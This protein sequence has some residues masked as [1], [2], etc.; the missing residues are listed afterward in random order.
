M[1]PTL[2]AIVALLVAGGVFV[3]A[4]FALVGTRRL[5]VEARREAGDRRARSVAAAL[6]DLPATLA[7]SQV[8][9]AACAVLL[10]LLGA[11]VVGGAWLR[12]VLAPLGWAP[13]L[14]TA[15]AVGAALLLVGVLQVLVGELVPRSLAISRPLE[16]ALV[17]VP[18]ARVLGRLLRPLAWL[19]DRSARVVS[20]RVLRVEAV[21]GAGGGHSLDELAR[22][23]TA[24]GE[25]GSLSGPQAS[26]LQRAIELGEVRA[27]Q[28]MVPRPDVTWLTADD[29]LED[30]RRRARATGHSRFPVHG[31][32]ED[33]VLGTVHVKDLLGRDRAAQARTSVTEVLQPVAIAPESQPLRRLLADLRRAHR[34][35]AV[36]VDEYGGTAGIV[37]VEDVLE[38][39]VGDIRDEFDRRTAAGVR[40]VAPGR[41][42]VAGRVRVEQLAALLGEPAPE[43]P[44]DTVAGLVLDQL[45]R[46][47][48]LGDACTLSTG[49]GEVRLE[50]TGVDD[51]RITEVT[52][53]VPGLADDP[54]PSGGH[55]QVPADRPGADRRGRA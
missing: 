27:G 18:V 53:T 3:A 7:T 51:V 15:V 48:E 52:V 26:L 6:D 33:E 35:F 41:H 38:V 45:G 20:E 5:P 55:D 13:P 10:G 25:Q 54:A 23:V 19:V 44:Y 47:A 21:R 22:I 2:L 16:V 37:T 42:V 24:S 43:G 49:A 4:E 9:N 1:L 32:S 50:V 39:L 36:V 28:V 29:T 11:S 31:E 14:T 34:T 30:L 40:R 17:V 12:P 46:I 8:G